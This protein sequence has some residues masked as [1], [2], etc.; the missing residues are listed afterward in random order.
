MVNRKT[1]LKPFRLKIPDGLE[2]FMLEIPIRPKAKARARIAKGGKSVYKDMKDR[3]WGKA[4]REYIKLNYNDIDPL[5]DKNG[6]TMIAICE[7]LSK[8]KTRWG[9]PM[10][11][12][13]DVSNYLKN[14]E[15]ELSGMIYKDDAGIFQT[16]IL[17]IWNDRN[18]ITLFII[19]GKEYK[20]ILASVLSGAGTTLSIL[21]F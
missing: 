12:R 13:P 9:E 19:P 20:K 5:D 7:V 1:Y 21:T 15:D 4:V 16:Y 11:N 3:Q 18:F 17:K 10:V 6:L 14:I 2:G 8:D